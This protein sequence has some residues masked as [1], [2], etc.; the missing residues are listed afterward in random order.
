MFNVAVAGAVLALFGAW[1]LKTYLK[2]RRT[3][4][5]VGWLPGPKNFLSARALFSRLLPNIPYVNRKPDWVWKRKYD[6]RF[7]NVLSL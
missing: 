7:S 1:A 6:C 4:N 5:T 3:M 2:Y